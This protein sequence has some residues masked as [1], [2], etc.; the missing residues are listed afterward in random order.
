M[1][2]L[3]FVYQRD[4]VLLGQGHGRSMQ[5][6]GPTL[7]TEGLCG[8]RGGES[9]GGVMEGRSRAKPLGRTCQRHVQ[10]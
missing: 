6:P 9:R 2:H 4:A 8:W 7:E 5:S 10:I 1:C 3:P